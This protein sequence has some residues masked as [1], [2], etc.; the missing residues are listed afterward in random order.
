MRLRWG[1]GGCRCVDA[2]P[3]PWVCAGDLPMA[4]PPSTSTFVICL[5]HSRNGQLMG[6]DGVPQRSKLHPVHGQ[7]KRREWAAV[8][9]RARPDSPRLFSVPMPTHPNT[10]TRNTR[11]APG[12]TRREEQWCSYNLDMVHAGMF[13]VLCTSWSV[14]HGWLITTPPP[15]QCATPSHP[16]RLS[17]PRAPPPTRRL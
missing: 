3:P 15:H 2:F 5:F 13:N 17:F 7:F 14:D 4:P 1:G 10:A 9:Q 8:D 6:N 11:R 16:P 12:R